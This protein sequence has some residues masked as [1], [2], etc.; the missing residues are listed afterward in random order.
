MSIRKIRLKLLLLFGLFLHWIPSKR[1]RLYNMVIVRVDAIGDYVLFMNA[2]LA[3][4]KKF[5]GKKVLLICADMVKP[6]A[7]G[8]SLYTDI[9]AFNRNRFAFSFLYNLKFLRKVRLIKADEVV[10]PLR[11]RHSTG[12]IIVANIKSAQKYAIRN[13][14]KSGIGGML[15]SLYTRLVEIPAYSSEIDSV[16][17]F[18]KEILS[19]SY[20]YKLNKIT[21]SYDKIFSFVLPSNFAV[22]AVS[23]SAN[24]KTWPAERFAEL[25][26]MIPSD[27]DIIL[28][29]SGEADVIRARA[30]LD[31]VKDKTRLC[32]MVNKTSVNDM[33]VLISHARFVIGNDSAAVHIAAASHVPSICLF[34]GAH[35]GRFLPYPKSIGN[36]KYHPRIVYYKMDC[37]N[38]NFKCKWPNAVPFPCLDKVSVDMAAEELSKLLIELKENERE[39]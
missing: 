12:D 29:G 38:C 30:I 35:F 15:N 31:I 21:L 32:N 18:T 34:H 16:E 8:E 24:V 10:Y 2:L 26:D 6:L 19:S 28:S 9:M 5:E 11:E 14:E 20:H 3:Y 23:S 33:F 13:D 22:I 7:E 25:I 17:L 27:Y 4:K 39:N 37:Y 36:I 1:S